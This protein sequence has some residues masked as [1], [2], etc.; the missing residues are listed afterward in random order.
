MIHCE[1]IGAW[2]QLE[3]I[4]VQILAVVA[5][6]KVRT[7]RTEVEKGS[8]WTVFGHG[9]V[10]PKTLGN[11]IQKSDLL[12]QR[13]FK[14]KGKQVNIPVPNCGDVRGPREAL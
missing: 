2:A 6:T 8:V 7:F 1:D 4:I 14:L 12:L 10:D 13:R 9:W 3:W 11:S 5:I